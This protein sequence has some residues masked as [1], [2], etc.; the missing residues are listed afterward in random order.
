MDIN[1]EQKNYEYAN[2]FHIVSMKDS[3]I[4]EFTSNIQSIKTGIDN[5]L[6]NPLDAFI[7]YN[8]LK[9]LL[10]NAK[11]EIDE[12]AQVEA[13]K[14]TEKTINY[15]GYSIT[16]TDGR[17]QLDYSNIQEWVEAK[18]NLKRIEEKY[19]MVE[20]STLLSIDQETGEVLEKPIVTFTKTSL[21]IKKV[22]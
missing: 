3:V 14:Y 8:E 6:I 20:K 11:K 1:N 13:D 2:A 17:K 18:E 19:K 16:K 9:K 5:G 4:G 10:D 12:I 21:T 15:N 7:V 22:K